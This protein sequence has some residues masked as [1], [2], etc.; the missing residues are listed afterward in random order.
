MVAS[1]RRRIASAKSRY[2]PRPV[3]P[4]PRP[5]SPHSLA[6]AGREIPEAGVLA[7]Q[8]VVALR[9]RDQARRPAVALRPGHPDAAVVPQRFAHEGEARLG[10]GAHRGAGGG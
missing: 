1:P 5:S 9:L 10:G 8:V 6:V 2:T 3:S 7:F 4:T